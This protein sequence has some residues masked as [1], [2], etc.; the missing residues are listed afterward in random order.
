MFVKEAWGRARGR[1]REQ[2]P[3]NK[4]RNRCRGRTTSRIYSHIP[5]I[6]LSKFRVNLYLC[7][8]V[9]N[10]TRPAKTVQSRARPGADA[11]ISQTRGRQS[12]QPEH[13]QYD[14]SCVNVCVC[15]SSPV[16][17]DCGM[18]GVYTDRTRS[19]LDSVWKCATPA[20]TTTRL[21][22]L[23][24]NTSLHRKRED[25]LITFATASCRLQGLT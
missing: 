16:A 1:S 11:T 22:R 7:F 4:Q 20:S 3:Q 5:S 19:L 24:A 25:C 21:Q 9:S 15:V 23:P 18:H 6:S 2:L 10:P 17:K 14:L 13:S 12:R 8:R